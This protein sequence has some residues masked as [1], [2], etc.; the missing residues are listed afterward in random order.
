MDIGNLAGNTIGSASSEGAIAVASNN[1]SSMEVYGIYYFPSA[2]V[3]ISNN[4]VA[5]ISA[6]NSGAGSL[7]VYGIRA[8]TTPTVV[9]SLQ[10]NVVGTASGP[11]SNSSTSVSSRIIGLY[12]Q[13]GAAAVSGNSIGQLSMNAP[14]VGTGISAGVIGLFVSTT[15]TLGNNVS[16]NTI[17]NL[18]NSHASAAVWVTGLEYTG[19]TTGTHVVQRNLIHSLSTPSTSATATVNGIHLQAGTTTYQNNMIALGG[20]MTANSPQVNGIHETITGTGGLSFYFNSVYIG[21]SGVA[22]GT[23]HSFALQSALVTNT[24]NFR[25]NVFFNA[26]SNGAATGKHYA[27]RVGGTAP[28]PAGLTSNNNVLLASG[29]G[30]GHR[31]VQRHRS[32]E[33]RRLAGRHRSGRRK[34]RRQPAVPRPGRRDAGPAHRTRRWARR[35]RAAASPSAPSATTSTARRAPA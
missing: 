3:T 25:D 21:G 18:S 11:I 15:S 29:T 2:A 7:V 30:G 12:S 4:T 27:I 28:N 31:P 9:N 33:P 13:T 17:R 10:N 20:D 23:G 22:S 5:G 8:Q 19:A 16:Q 32:G 35:S 1:G 26:R 34:L 6:T 14:N 24:R